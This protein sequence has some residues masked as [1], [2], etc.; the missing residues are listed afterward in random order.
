VG[1]LGGR[2]GGHCRFLG[3]IPFLPYFV[4]ELGITGV[5]EV[6]LW[7]SALFAAQAVTMTIFSPIWGRSPTVLGGS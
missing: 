6:G 5:E 4:Q 1:D 7:S 3:H 2:A